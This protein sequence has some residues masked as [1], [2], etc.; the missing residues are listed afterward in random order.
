MVEPDV[1]IVMSDQPKA[2][3]KSF[4]RFFFALVSAGFALVGTIR[5]CPGEPVVALDAGWKFVRG[6]PAGAETPRFDD[7]QWTSVDL[8]HDWSIFGPIEADNPAG[9]PGGFFPTGIGWYRK[10]F[11]APQAWSG[12]HVSIQFDGVYMLCGVW[13]NGHKLGRHTFGFTPFAYDLTSFL[14][15]GGKNVVAVR[16]DNSRPLNCRWYSGSGI[17]RHVRLD[18]REPIHIGQFGVFV[19]T[20]E[21]SAGAARLAISITAENGSDQLN[22]RVEYATQIF[23][24]GKDGNP[25]GGA[26]ATSLR[27]GASFGIID[28]V[29]QRTT[30]VETT[31]TLRDPK[32]W[33]PETPNLYVAVTIAS[34]EGRIVD[35]RQTTFGVR[36]IAVSVEKGFVLNGR[37][38]KLYGACVHDDNGPLG[39]AAFDRAEV[40][41]VE[42]LKAAGFNAVRCA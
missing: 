29:R 23:E 30:T 21:V 1:V 31:S 40:R 32:L 10:A 4:V 3:E 14:N 24:V 8:P 25:V 15:I 27:V 42:L 26:V 16:V 41:R 20:I 6:D 38:I 13:I 9:S 2:R 33:S 39:V 22:P 12:K 35:S 37:Q 36:T 19:R 11:D 17:Y 28:R 7:D 5:V 34:I 18:V